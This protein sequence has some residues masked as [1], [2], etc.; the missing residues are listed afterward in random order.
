MCCLPRVS[1]GGSIPPLRTIIVCGA[2]L[3]T[4]TRQSRETAQKRAAPHFYVE[5]VEKPLYEKLE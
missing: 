2:A 3:K 4:L 5:A 1:A